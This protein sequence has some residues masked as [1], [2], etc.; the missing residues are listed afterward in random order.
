MAEPL[1]DAEH[2]VEGA[3]RGEVQ[4]A[5]LVSRTGAAQQAVID[6]GVAGGAGRVG[7]RAVPRPPVG[8]DEPVG[9]QGAAGAGAWHAGRAREAGGLVVAAPEMEILHP[10]TVYTPLAEILQLLYLMQHLQ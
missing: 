2:E 3:G 10:C 7:A 8:Q 6:D 9:A 4:D 1:V 5:G